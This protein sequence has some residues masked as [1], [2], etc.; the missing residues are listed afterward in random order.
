MLT[1][2]ML[3]NQNFKKSL[4]RQ[5]FINCTAYFYP[6]IFPFCENKD[7]KNYFEDTKKAFITDSNCAKK[8]IVQNAYLL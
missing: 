4:K 5:I 2:N 7:Q 6:S 3:T 1:I 8:K